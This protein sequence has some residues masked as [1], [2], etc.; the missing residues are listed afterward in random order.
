M[1]RASG[2]GKGYVPPMRTDA[3]A[4]AVRAGGWAALAVGACGIARLLVAAQVYAVAETARTPLRGHGWDLALAAV[5]A[6]AAG[7]QA[8]A[9][10]GV[11]RRLG[12]DTSLILTASAAGWIGAALALAGAGV[13]AFRALASSGPALATGLLLG[14][15]A[16]FATALWAAGVCAADWRR[17]RLP[18]WLRVTGTLFAVFSL[19]A[20]VLSP[21]GL[22]AFPFALAWWTGLGVALLRAARSTSG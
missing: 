16:A 6:L 14:W 2:R 8:L 4:S 22:L 19:A 21:F 7:A 5:T 10:Q 13:V 11:R 9:V 20:A 15:L 3:D 18:A 17:L 12:P 1:T